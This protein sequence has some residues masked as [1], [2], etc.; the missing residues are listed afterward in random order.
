MRNA[1]NGRSLVGSSPDLPGMLNRIRFQLN[2]GS[3]PESELQNDWREFGED[4]FIFE[5]LDPLEPSSD[6]AYDPSEDLRV[7]LRMWIEKMR[8]LSA[9]M[10]GQAKRI[11]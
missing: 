4:A 9:P 10:Y 8:G 1:V 2:H 5:T 11:L 3:H 6:S 7:L